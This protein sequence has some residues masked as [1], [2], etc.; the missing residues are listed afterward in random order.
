MTSAISTIFHRKSWR[1]QCAW[2]TTDRQPSQ[3]IIAFHSR[4][5][6]SAASIADRRRHGNITF[7]AKFP[8]MSRRKN[9]HKL[10]SG[11]NWKLIQS[12][13]TPREK[14]ATFRLHPYTKHTPNRAEWRSFTHLLSVFHRVSSDWDSTE[15]VVCRRKI[16]LKTSQKLFDSAGE[17]QRHRSITKRVASNREADPIYLGSLLAV[18]S[19]L[20]Q[21]GISP[22]RI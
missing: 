14:R 18:A 4:L 1:T 20:L 9:I 13:I 15:V 10:L 8:L 3:C 12:V 16:T 7:S 5:T 21:C 2:E 19:S 22:E 11:I 6:P 17:P